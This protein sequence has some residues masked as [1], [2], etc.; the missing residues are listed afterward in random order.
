MTTAGTGRRGNLVLASL[1]GILVVADGVLAAI[2]WMVWSAQRRGNL[3]GPEA[4][5][6]ILVGASAAVGAVALLLA[7]IAVT[8]GSRGHRAARFASALAW[9]RLAGVIIALIAM[10]IRLGISAIA[11]P[12]ETFGAVVAVAD[13]LFALIVTGVAVRR[14][15]HG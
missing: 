1:T 7:L 9:L 3:S 11:G 12:F 13:A 5:T 6:F 10:A 15:G 4:A 8:R 14:T 2:G